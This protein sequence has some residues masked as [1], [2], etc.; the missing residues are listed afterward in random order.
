MTDLVVA[1]SG[2][3]E[4]IGKSESPAEEF[5][6]IDIKGIDAVKFGTLHS[7]LTGRSFD[8]LQPEYEPVVSVSDDGPW[9]VRLPSDFVARLAALTGAEKQAAVSKWAATEEF[10]LD[11]WTESDVTEAFDEIAVLAR[12]AKDAGLSLF[13]W[14][15]L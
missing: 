3:A 5:D 13:L 12:K 1:A 11:G 4:R 7:I 9:V 15:S 10:E 14:E 2:D 8:D 6:G